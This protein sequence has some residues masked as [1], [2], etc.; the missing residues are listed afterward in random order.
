MIY[1]GLR[2]IGTEAGPCCV[3][4]VDDDREIVAT[5]KKMFERHGIPVCVLAYDGSEAVRVF[6]DLER[7]PTVILMDERMSFMS[8]TEATRELVKNDPKLGIIFIS[9]DA[10]SMDQAF[11]AGAKVFL[12]KPTS[13][14]VIMDAVKLVRRNCSTNK[15]YYD[16]YKG[17]VANTTN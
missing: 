10:N 16:G 15:Y 2:G 12:K 4:I 5:F 9:A 1:G 8:G 11:N 3:G 13:I 17:F 14:N 7:K 6:G